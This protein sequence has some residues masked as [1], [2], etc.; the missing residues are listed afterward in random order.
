MRAAN[1]AFG[2][3]MHLDCANSINEPVMEISADCAE[4]QLGA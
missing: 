3:G 2:L 1:I 4:V